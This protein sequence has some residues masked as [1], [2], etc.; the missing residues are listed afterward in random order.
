MSVW[1][2]LNLGTWLNLNLTLFQIHV[3]A[4][5]VDSVISQIRTRYRRRETVVDTYLLGLGSGVYREFP[6]YLLWRWRCC[7]RGR[8]GQTQKDN[9][10]SGCNQGLLLCMSAAQDTPCHDVTCH[11]PRCPNLRRR[12]DPVLL[13]DFRVSNVRALYC[14]HSPGLCD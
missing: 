12:S 13:C 14:Q 10:A 7:R 9:L 8:H 6:L 1:G 3:R 5:L 11:N 4:R 2:T